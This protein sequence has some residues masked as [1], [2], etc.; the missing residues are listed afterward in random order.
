MP[1]CW[2][3]SS[4]Q[5]SNHS[6]SAPRGSMKWIQLQAFESGGTRC[7]TQWKGVGTVDI[8]LHSLLKS[9]CLQ[10]LRPSSL[11]HL[12]LI[13]PASSLGKWGSDIATPYLFIDAYMITDICNFSQNKTTTKYVSPSWMCL[14]IKRCVLSGFQKARND[15]QT[16]RNHRPID[17]QKFLFFF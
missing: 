5:L 1:S 12:I 2:G 17:W 8:W 10:D 13:A 14:K 3:R 7:F 16:E 4:A 15:E 9:K 6:I 11:I